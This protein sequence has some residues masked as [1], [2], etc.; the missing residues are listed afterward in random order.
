MNRDTWVPFAGGLV[1]AVFLW[2]FV[3]VGYMLVD[4]IGRL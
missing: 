3:I 2:L 1:A 4:W